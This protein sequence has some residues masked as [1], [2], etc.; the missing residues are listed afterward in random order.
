MSHIVT[1][2]KAHQSL[3]DLVSEVEQTDHPIFLTAAGEEKAALISIQTYHRLVNQAE[4]EFRRQQ[5]LAVTP[6]ASEESWQAGFAELEAL[7][8]AHFSGVSEETLQE[9][10]A[11]ALQANP[12]ALSSEN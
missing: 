12:S 10:I 9:E 2:E 1:I 8:A 4:R 7:G 5:A 6:A 11:A 3:V